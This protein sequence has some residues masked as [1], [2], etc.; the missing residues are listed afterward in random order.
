M[1]SVF[2]KIRRDLL[3]KANNYDKRGACLVSW[4]NVCWPKS[5][6]G[7]GILD[8]NL[9]SRALRLRWKWFEWTDGRRPWVGTTVPCDQ[10]DLSLFD[11]CTQFSVG[12][13]NIAMLWTTRCLDGVAPA[14]MVPSL[15]K[16]TRLE[17]LTVVHVMP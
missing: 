14:E 5:L 12:R 6:G 4:K 17:K 11:A 16:L 1:V 2:V 7:L 10:I 3:W 8:L 15:F 13:G 9:F